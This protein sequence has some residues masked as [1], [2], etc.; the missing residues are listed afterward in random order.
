M[1]LSGVECSQWSVQLLLQSELN[2]PCLSVNPPDVPLASL[3]ARL[4]N[5]ILKT[6]FIMDQPLKNL[7][8]TSDP[9]QLP[10]QGYK[11]LLVL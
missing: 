11:Q 10:P 2:G 9:M 8:L 1:N 6:N 4:G 3:L 5:I 7:Y